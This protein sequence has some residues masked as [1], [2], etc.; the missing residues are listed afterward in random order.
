MLGAQAQDEDFPLE[1]PDAL[2]PN[3]FEYFGFGQPGQG[4]PPVEP[5]GQGDQ[6]WAPWEQNVEQQVDDVPPLI[7][8]QL[9]QEAQAA[10]EI[11]PIH[12]VEEIIQAVNPNVVALPEAEEHV[13]AMDTDTD[14]DSKVH[15]QA[16]LPIPPVEIVPFPDFNNLQPLMPEEIQEDE[17]LGWIDDA[18]AFME[19]PQQENAMVMQQSVNDALNE[20]ASE[21]SQQLPVEQLETNLQVLAPNSQNARPS[22]NRENFDQ[23]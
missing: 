15:P 23:V 9:A 13:L 16:H 18:D 22:L 3:H 11:G 14:T 10:E 21:L 12:P 17:L 1:D 5:N 2:D 19:Q 7:P 20:H 6:G 4:P 8:L